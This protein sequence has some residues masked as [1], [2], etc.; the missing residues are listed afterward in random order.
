MESK[1]FKGE[2][3]PLV[4]TSAVERAVFGCLRGT[5]YALGYLVGLLRYRVFQKL[6]LFDVLS[7]MSRGLAAAAPPDPQGRPE[8]SSAGN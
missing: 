6:D 1:T 3:I 7:A 5:S 8:S 4:R 2:P